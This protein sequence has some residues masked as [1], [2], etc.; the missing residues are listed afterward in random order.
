MRHP[1]SPGRGDREVE[2]RHSVQGDV[3]EEQLG[4]AAEIPEAGLRREER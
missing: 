3:A 2:L 4:E 1:G